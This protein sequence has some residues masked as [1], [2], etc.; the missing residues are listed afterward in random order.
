MREPIVI[1]DDQILDGRNRY[2][3][4]QAAGRNDY[5]V[6]EFE[7]SESDAMAL[8]ISG[9]LIRRHL[10]VSQRA[11]VA[12]EL[13]NM[14]QGQRTDLLQNLQKVSQADAAR[15]L[16]VSTRS[17]AAA[18][19]VKKAD[20]ELA[21][22]VIAGK[23]SLS[24]AD[25]QIDARKGRSPIAMTD[26]EPTPAP[27]APPMPKKPKLRSLAAIGD[28]LQ[29]LHDEICEH[30]EIATQKLEGRSD[31]W[32]DSEAGVEAQQRADSLDQAAGHLGDAIG[33]LQESAS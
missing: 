25:A 27:A 28:D 8:V 20:A 11:M 31:K 14:A 33:A 4:A 22:K 29:S 18:G 9:N 19:K 16:K 3:A 5:P 26:K 24:A 15:M 30:F 13:A 10:T 32:I 7:G 1:W 23:F 17:V 6:V 21:A 12:V 2:R